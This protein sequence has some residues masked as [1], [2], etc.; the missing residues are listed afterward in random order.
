[1]FCLPAAGVRLAVES[2]DETAPI[3]GVDRSL[4]PGG[5]RGWQGGGTLRSGDV[6]REGR[7][8]H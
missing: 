1:M 5:E 6:S 4:F 7:S 3:D 8:S 2:G